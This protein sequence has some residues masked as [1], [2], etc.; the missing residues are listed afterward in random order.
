MSRLH[1]SEQILELVGNQ[2]GRYPRWPVREPLSFGKY[3]LLERIAVGGMAEV[4]KAKSF[5]VEGFEKFLAIKRILPSLGDDEEFIKM[6]IDE[7]KIVGQLV[8][9]NIGQIFEL[10]EVDGAHFIAMEYVRGRDL[11]QIRERY[12]RLSR[13]MPIAMICFIMSNVLDGLHYAHTKTA[14]DGSPLSIIHRDCSPQNVLVSYEG[15]VRL[16]D[17]GIAKAASSSQQTNGG[18]LKGKF[19][20][21]SPEQVSGEPLDHRSD[22]FALGAVL[23]ELLVGRSLFQGDSDFATLENVREARVDAPSTIRGDVSKTLEDIV[24]RALQKNPNDRYQTAEAMKDD[25]QS[26]LRERSEVISARW[27]GEEIRDVFEKEYEKEIESMA[28]FQKISAPA[29]QPDNMNIEYSNSEILVSSSVEP[30]PKESRSSSASVEHRSFPATFDDTSGS[31]QSEE[32]DPITAELPRAHSLAVSPPKPSSLVSMRDVLVVILVGCIGFAAFVGYQHWQ[33][34]KIEDELAA[35]AALLS[36]LVIVMEDG[37]GSE[38]LVDGR[39]HG[40]VST[41]LSID[42]LPKGEHHVVVRRHGLKDVRVVETLEAGATKVVRIR[43][44]ARPTVGKFVLKGLEKND[45]IFVNEQEASSEGERKILKLAAN[46][47]HHI[48]IRR[49]RRV[50]ENFK[51]E[52]EAGAMISHRLP[53]SDEGNDE[54]ESDQSATRPPRD[55]VETSKET[56]DAGKGESSSD[57]EGVGFFSAFTKP[58]ARV[59]VDGKDTGRFTPISAKEQI[60]LEAGVHIIKFVVDEQSFTFPVTIV[61]GQPFKLVENLPVKKREIEKLPL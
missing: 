12:R 7:A 22:L 44:E 43:F 51:V 1:F 29:T 26:I 18:I 13:P 53:Q 41:Q 33:S 17:F 5:G 9:P 24:L 35:K 42:E 27:L 32:S 37:I 14:L 54:S 55:N 47:K 46:R 36:T 39:S 11:L 25:L 58:Y 59:F 8:H 3:L 2:L 6:F 56:L 49:N 20:Y 34:K 19:G 38:V 45:R 28:R 40:M 48:V 4:F 50:I 23:Y 15:E 61:G 16:I 57:N 52:I 21:M 60:E 10:G 30:A 31:L